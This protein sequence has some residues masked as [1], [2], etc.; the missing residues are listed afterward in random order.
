MGNIRRRV[1]RLGGGYGKA[2]WAYCTA[3]AQFLT[4]SGEPMTAAEM[5]AEMPPGVTC[6]EEWLRAMQ[7]GEAGVDD[8]S[9]SDS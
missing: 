7:P 2:R 9:K 1:E 4:E 3:W 6:Y 8:H 5:D